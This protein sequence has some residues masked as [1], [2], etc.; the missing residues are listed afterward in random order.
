MFNESRLI[1]RGLEVPGDRPV[2]KNKPEVINLDGNGPRR[3][4]DPFKE[5]RDEAARLSENIV[6]RDKAVFEKAVS[7]LMAADLN[8]EQA[9]A[10]LSDD[11]NPF[12]VM[13]L[14][15]A[16]RMGKE[17][18]TLNLEGSRSGWIDFR[19]GGAVNGTP[20]FILNA[21]NWKDKIYPQLV[22][23]LG[24]YYIPE[25]IEIA[26]LY[27][28]LQGIHHVIDCFRRGVS[29]DSSSVELAKWEISQLKNGIKPMDLVKM[30]KESGKNP[31]KKEQQPV[32]KQESSNVR[33]EPNRDDVSEAV[34]QEM[35]V[36]NMRL[37]GINEAYERL[38]KEKQE[39]MRNTLR[40]QLK[41]IQTDDDLSRFNE[42]LDVEVND[43]VQQYPEFSGLNSRVHEL[44]GEVEELAASGY[45]KDEILDHVYDFSLA[46]LDEERNFADQCGKMEANGDYD[47]T[48]AKHFYGHLVEGYMAAIGV[49]YGIE[50]N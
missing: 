19:R 29:P 16:E 35:D 45:S 47:L 50:F 20:N 43:F 2:I 5:K 41:A 11:T 49:R 3:K 44:M 21:L 39:M 27:H 17:G 8:R 24:S 6:E 14:D 32:E 22:S 30:E 13:F 48:A 1:F 10:I 23:V 33:E 12:I 31:V 9:E 36:Q 25:I 18:W 37:A 7:L 34:D 28:E 46:D 26:V 42:S 40:P 15:F 38:F 4:F